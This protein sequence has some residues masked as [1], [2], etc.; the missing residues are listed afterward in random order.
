MS[1]H[2]RAALTGAALLGLFAS[3]T[4]LAQQAAQAGGSGLEEIVVTARRREEN[5]QSVPVAVN[6][7]SGEALRE[8]NIYSIVQLQA[9]TPSY[10]ANNYQG[11][12]SALLPHVR[13][14]PGVRTYFA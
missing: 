10:N 8:K 14:L 6:A 12:E 11:R 5:I 4:V 9:Q 1:I 2:R 7:F 3:D 13:S